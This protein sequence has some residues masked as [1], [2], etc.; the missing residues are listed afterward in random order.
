MLSIMQSFSNNLV[1]QYACK[2]IIIQYIT[3]LCM[4]IMQ[5]FLSVD[6]RKLLKVMQSVSYETTKRLQN[7]K[8]IF[9][10]FLSVSFILFI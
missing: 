9:P 10:C 3:L 2:T 8:F 7:L 4:G 6:G 1:Q 5:F